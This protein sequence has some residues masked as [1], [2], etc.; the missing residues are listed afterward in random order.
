MTESFT[1]QDAIRKV[2]KILS[3]KYAFDDYDT[4]ALHLFMTLLSQNSSCSNK[5]TYTYE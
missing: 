2:V 1:T 5:I 3:D 4:E